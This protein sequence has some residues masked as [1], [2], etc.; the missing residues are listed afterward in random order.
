M[1][2]N[3]LIN[4]NQQNKMILLDVQQLIYLMQKMLYILNNFYLHTF[5]VIYYLDLQYN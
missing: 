1:I 4:K 5:F 3:Y 2:N